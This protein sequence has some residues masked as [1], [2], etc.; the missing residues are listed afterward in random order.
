[1]KKLIALVVA[2]M[3]LVACAKTV[4]SVQQ[5][6]EPVPLAVAADIVTVTA[7]VEAIDYAKR[8]MKIKGPDGNVYTV[9]SG[10]KIQN[11]DKIKKG[12]VIVAEFAESIAVFV[13]NSNEKPNVDTQGNVVVAPKGSKPFGEAVGTIEITALVQDVDYKT[14]EV[15]IQG[16]EGNVAKIEVS[17]DVKNLDK[18]K[19]GDNIIIRY[20][21]A[22][23]VAVVK[24]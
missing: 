7:S 11:F 9:K 16:P 21:E 20:T 14:R 6:Q 1:M 12:D 15:T 5:N 24:K 22:V 23:A 10:A 13:S 18:L 19:K 2:M 17:P 4:P 3:I 8:T